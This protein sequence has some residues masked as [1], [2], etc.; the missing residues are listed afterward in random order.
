MEHHSVNTLRRSALFSVSGSALICGTLVMGGIPHVQAS[1][2]S[3]KGRQKVSRCHE[4]RGTGPKIAQ[5]CRKPADLSASSQ[6]S[7]VSPSGNADETSTV[8]GGTENLRVYG[9]SRSYTAPAVEAWGKT[10]VALKDIPHSI[11]IIT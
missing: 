8:D 2:L 9:T 3:E 6:S 5:T 1:E 7:A 4:A 10:P 11:S